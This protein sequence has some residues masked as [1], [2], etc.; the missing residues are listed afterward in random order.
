MRIEIG[1]AARGWS[2]GIVNRWRHSCCEVPVMVFHEGEGVGGRVEGVL[3][4]DNVWV[5]F[6]GRIIDPDV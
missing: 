3:R 2:K 4:L 6:E 5:D 1:H